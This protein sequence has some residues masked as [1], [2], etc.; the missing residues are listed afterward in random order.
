MTGE[1]NEVCTQ[2]FQKSSTRGLTVEYRNERTEGKKIHRRKSITY[3]NKCLKESE[4]HRDKNGSR[5]LYKMVNTER[6]VTNPSA[7]VYRYG[8]TEILD[9]WIEHFDE[10][11]NRNVNT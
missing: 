9:R 4:E 11:L 10:F 3:A 6:K 1:K 8:K 7:T 5:N 2:M